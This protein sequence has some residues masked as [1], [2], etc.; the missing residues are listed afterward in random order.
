MSKNKKT[1]RVDWGNDK[2]AAELL[3]AVKGDQSKLNEIGAEVEESIRPIIKAFLD[4]NIESAEDLD[5]IIAT[6]P[7]AK[8]EFD[9]MVKSKTMD[10]N[11]RQTVRNMADMVL[12]MQIDPDMIRDSV[13]KYEFP[14]ERI[15]PAL[16]RRAGNATATRMIKQ[17]RYH[18][19]DEFAQV[20][21]GKRPG[22]RLQFTD[23][24]RKATKKEQDT[25]A[26][27]QDVFAR[28]F[29]YV[30]N[31]TQPDMGKFLRYAYQDYFDLDKIAIENIRT[32]ASSN[33]KRN[34][35]GAPLAFSLAD[36][37]TVFHVLPKTNHTNT[38]VDMYRWDRNDFDS[39][40]A[41]IGVHY[42]YIDE[43]RY[44]QVDR[45][46]ERRAGYKED[47]MILSHAYGTT[48]ITEQF[49]GYSI[50]EQALE[51]IRYIID[52]IIYNYTRRTTGTMPKGMINIEGA[53]E[54]GFSREEMELFRKL[55]WGIASG[56]KDKWK[57]PV[58]GTPKGVKPTFIKFHDS[59]KEMEDFL[60]VSTLFS[61]LCTFAG[62]D[63]ENISLASQKNTLGKQR[64]FSKSEEEGAE[65][66]SQDAGLRFFLSH[67]AG[68]INRSEVVEEL[69]GIE[70]LE[71]R[72]LGLD[73][74]DETKKR[75]LD[76]K[77]LQT[78][79]SVND[80]LVAADKKE[81]ELMMGDVNIFD[82]P[83]L[84]NATIQ[85]VVLQAL[86]A[87]GGGMMDGADGF[88]EENPYGDIPGDD[89][90][91][92]LDYL[93][94]EE[95][96]EPDEPGSKAAPPQPEQPGKKQPKAPPIKKSQTVEVRVIS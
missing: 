8:A 28:K 78:T 85:A 13:D 17:Y 18:Q 27:F 15:K 4:A 22:F 31:H 14:H 38:G 77:A 23:A 74:E 42:E 92:G 35:R 84:G 46:G 76:M 16:L 56:R 53:T 12:S 19:L 87:Q 43:I 37:G 95:F 52:N 89:E 48:D 55:I 29:F 47:Q 82:I 2:A 61:I 10:I 51:I 44:I 33:K 96:K 68:I 70:G 7:G 73:V 3:K 32:N 45:H 64:L 58:L 88:D 50:V 59:S 40:M 66:R 36:A 49:M 71:W 69:T 79:M 91:G 11:M 9:A 90:E 5:K 20:S 93:G 30:P 94:G 81:F 39:K 26:Q 60:W 6:D 67:M 65:S 75:D 80:L 1:D 62:M 83:A 41:E 72:W 34:Y 86:Q 63:P 57:Y 54:D 25:I 24:E 21:D